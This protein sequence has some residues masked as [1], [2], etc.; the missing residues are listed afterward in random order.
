MMARQKS[1]D[2]IVVEH[3][4]AMHQRAVTVAKFI[5]SRKRKLSVDQLARVIFTAWEGDSPRA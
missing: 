3:R 4:L 5:A 2:Q 1:N